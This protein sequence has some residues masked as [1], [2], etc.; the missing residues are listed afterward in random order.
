MS[1][2]IAPLVVSSALILAAC[3]SED[4]DDNDPNNPPPSSWLVGEQGEMLQL[5][6]SESSDEVS[7]YPLRHAG[8]LNAIACLGEATAW[9]AGDEGAVLLSRDAGAQW[10]T[11]EIDSKAD[12]QAVA[13]SEGMPEGR[14]TIW[15]AGHDGSVLRSEDGGTHWS[16]IDGPDVDWSSVAT[17]L[18]G[19]IA[20]FSGLDGSV[21]RSAGGAALEPL[22]PADGL[23]LYDLAMTHDGDTIVAVGEAGRVMIGDTQGFLSAPPA[24]DRDLHAVHLGANADTIIAVGEASVVVRVE[25]GET[26]V[27]ELEGDH[28]LFGLH[29]RADGIGQTVGEHGTV[30]LTEDG[31]FHW[32]S[33]STGRTIDLLAVDDFHPGSHL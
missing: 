11:I 10:T 32:R 25:A 18:S 20:Y 21:W 31:G 13:V 12:L 19:E 6:A 24:T 5:T 4:K 14:E 29:L 33:V 28:A 8:N 1:I 15:V 30:W 22:H 26:Q 23:A 27:Q 3:T 9:V 7:T 17:D 16:V 2:R